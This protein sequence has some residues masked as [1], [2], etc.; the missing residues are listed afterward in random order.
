MRDL[1]IPIG[2]FFL[3]LGVLLAITPSAGAPLTDG[4][5]NLYVGLVALV[6][7]AGMLLLA[8]RRG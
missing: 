5:V 7:G 3:L 4:P 8:R 1:R 6:F 2:F